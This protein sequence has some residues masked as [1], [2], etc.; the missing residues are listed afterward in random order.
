MNTLVTTPKLFKSKAVLHKGLPHIQW[1]HSLKVFGRKLFGW[2]TEYLPIHP[3]YYS[4][5]KENTHTKFSVRDM[6]DDSDFVRI[7]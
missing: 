3:M 7:H 4:L 6:P 5:F 1:I 2:K